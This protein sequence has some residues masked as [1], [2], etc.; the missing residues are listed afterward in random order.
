MTFIVNKFSKV[1]ASARL[2]A[3]TD[4]GG[5]PTVAASEGTIMRFGNLAGRLTVFVG[6][7]AVDATVAS[8]GRFGPDPCAA[9]VDWSAFAAWA[10]GLS[11]DDAQPFRHQ[12]LG[13]CV[14]VPRQI[15]GIGL[16]YRAHA[17]EAGS[18]ITEDFP[19]VFTKFPT[20]LAG[21]DTVV[22]LPDGDNDYEAEL[23]VVVGRRAEHV[24]ADDAWNHVA[25]V[26]VG[27]DLTERRLQMAGPAPQFS[28]A[29][30]Y[31][32]F[33]P[34]GPWIVTT[35]E[36]TDPDDLELWCSLDGKCVQHTRTS[37]LIFSVPRLIALLSGVTPLLP[38]D[39]LF[40]G[41]PSGVGMGRRPPQY[42]RAGQ[43]LVTA[44]TGL[45]EIR[46]TFR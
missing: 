26:T 15:F 13:P 32:G 33:A 37:D 24:A 45:G 39:L 25:G 40:T 4:R 30:S 18:R 17:A 3:D 20:S 2:L 23:V 11:P 7:G 22:S 10:R 29:K 9:F 44:V 12:D 34:I 42:L 16:N 31:P 8:H 14:P 41:T 27:Q 21:P 5:R 1:L 43:T 6:D 35:D 46:Q 19:L 28:M 38:G 36:F